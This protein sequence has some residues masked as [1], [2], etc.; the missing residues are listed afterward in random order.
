M[1][2]VVVEAP[3]IE[4]Y[5]RNGHDEEQRS[6]PKRARRTDQTPRAPRKV[7]VVATCRTGADGMP[8]SRVA[9]A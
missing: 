5:G 9:P 2:A 6:R 7:T 8:A 1:Q 4:S 3:G